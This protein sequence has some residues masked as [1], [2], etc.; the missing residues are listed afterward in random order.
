ML[1]LLCR[2][3][4]LWTLTAR[5][6]ISYSDSSGGMLDTRSSSQE[7]VM[8]VNLH[9]VQG[10]SRVISHP[11]YQ[12]VCILYACRGRRRL[13]YILPRLVAMIGKVIHSGARSARVLRVSSFLALGLVPL[14]QLISY[15]ILFSNSPHPSVVLYSELVD[16][17]DVHLYREDTN[18][19]NDGKTASATSRQ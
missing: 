4:L 13:R 11:H 10:K 9:H 2:T 18:F 15:A 14:G 19:I 3:M 7:N 16:M 17:Q 6:E 5:D 1:L 8:E 12:Q